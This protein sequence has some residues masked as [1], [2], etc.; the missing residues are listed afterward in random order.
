[1]DLFEIQDIPQQLPLETSV[2]ELHMILDKIDSP[3]KDS[4]PLLF[5][6]FRLKEIATIL[7]MNE[8]TVKTKMYRSL[9]AL[10]QILE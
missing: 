10:R 3:E 9:N 2:A 7:D 4:D 5:E 1:M 8:N 6:G